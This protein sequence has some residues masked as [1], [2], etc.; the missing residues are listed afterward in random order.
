MSINNNNAR[1]LREGEEKQ[2][3]SKPITRDKGDLFTEVWLH[4]EL[5]VKWASYHFY[6]F[7]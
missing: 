3:T 7:W 6:L 1:E 2:I 4:K 5:K